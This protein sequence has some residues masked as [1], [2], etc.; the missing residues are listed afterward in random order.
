[1]ATSPRDQG[2]RR[3]GPSTTTP[4][5]CAASAT[6][7][8]SATRSSLAGRSAAWSRGVRGA[9][10]RPPRQADPA[11][12]H[13]PAQY[14]RLHERVPPSRRR[15]AAE[16]ARHFW[17]GGGPRALTACA[18]TC[19]PLYGPSRAGPGRRGPHRCQPRLAQ[20]PRLRQ[21]RGRP[22]PELARVT[23]PVLVV[24]GDLDPICGAATAEIVAALPNRPGALLPVPQRRASH[25]PRPARPVLAAPAGVHGRSG[26]AID[27]GASHAGRNRMSASPAVS[28]VPDRAR[29]PGA[30]AS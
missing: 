28:A 19:A 20:R 4:R 29:L 6:S 13:G 22:A 18:E 17:S 21:R 14:R 3:D 12:D 27:P 5:T 10:P 16:I 9:P 2:P 7:S 8:A 25:P 24:A 23:C 11:V 1:M 15:Q 26:G 30:A